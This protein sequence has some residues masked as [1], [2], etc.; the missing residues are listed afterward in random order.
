LV[1]FG[2]VQRFQFAPQ[3]K[4]VVRH[5]RSGWKIIVDNLC[6]PF[7]NPQASC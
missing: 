7:C 6:D 2:L 3:G 5:Y 1:T 4:K